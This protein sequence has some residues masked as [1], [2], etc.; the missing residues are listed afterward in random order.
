[1]AITK[2]DIYWWF[3]RINNNIYENREYLTQLD[4]QIGDADHG[5]N[6]SRGFEKVKEKIDNLNGTDDIGTI[7]KNVALVLISN[8]GGASGSLYGSFFL[9]GFFPASKKQELTDEE[10]FNVFEMGVKGIKERGKAEIGDKTMV[11]VWEP[12]LEKMRFNLQEGK[13]IRESS[14][15]ILQAAEDAKNNSMDLVAKKGRASILGEQ[16]RGKLDPGI[17]STYLIIKSL[18]EVLH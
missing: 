12:V 10:F 16:T 13:T 2:T 7:F 15:D 4:S 1:M 14:N 5:S 18:S 8:V 6:I 3:D 9:K 11:D 17:F